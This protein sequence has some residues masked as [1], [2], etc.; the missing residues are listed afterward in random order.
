MAKKPDKSEDA[1]DIESED[2]GAEP[3][4]YNEPNPIFSPPDAV[5]ATYTPSEAEWLR[6]SNGAAYTRWLELTYGIQPDGSN[7]PKFEPA[8]D[9]MSQEDILALMKAVRKQ[10]EAVEPVEVAKAAEPVEAKAAVTKPAVE[11]APVKSARDE[12]TRSGHRRT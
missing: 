8:S 12:D 10:D 3:A 5:L 6:V 7:S 4:A 2:T 11:V 1:L 9:E